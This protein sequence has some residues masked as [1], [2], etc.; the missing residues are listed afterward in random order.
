MHSMHGL[1]QFTSISDKTIYYGKSTHE[2]EM[3]KLMCLRDLLLA[4]Q[5]FKYIMILAPQQNCKLIEYRMNKDYRHFT[6]S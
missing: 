6:Y 3:R 4:P 2:Q 5:V 1:S